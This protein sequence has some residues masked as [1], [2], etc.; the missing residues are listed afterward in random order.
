VR[1]AKKYSDLIAWQRAMDL[2]T[3]V[4]Q[5]SMGFPKAEIYGLTSQLR[6]AAVSVPSNIAEGYGRSGRREFAHALSIALGSLAEVETQILIAERLGYL[7]ADSREGL[8]ELSMDT[9]RIVVGLMNSMERHA[10]A[11]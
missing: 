8:I 7:A 1:I 10:K 5:V 9:G 4:Y 6:R 3:R 2:V 11:S